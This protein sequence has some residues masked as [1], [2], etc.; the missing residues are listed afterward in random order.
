MEFKIVQDIVANI[1]STV[2]NTAI[3]S[4]RSL[5][6][7]TFSTKVTNFPKT[8]EVKG[9]VVVGNQK[10]VEKQL[11]KIEKP[12]NPIL[13]AIRSIRFPKS[14]E[15]SNFPKPE[16]YPEP[17][18]SVEVSKLPPI[19]FPTT[20]EV[21]NQ[22]T[23]ELRDIRGQVEKVEKAVKGLKLN[24]SINVQAP[25][26]ERVLVPPA[27]VTVQEKEID[28]DKLAQAVASQIPS[29]DYRKLAD[30]IGKKLAEGLVSV[31]GGGGSGRR[32]AYDANGR[33]L[34]T[35]ST[36]AVLKVKNYADA[37]YK[38]ICLAEPGTALSTS[39]WKIVRETIATEDVDFASVGAFTNPATNLSVVQ[40][41][42]YS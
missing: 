33:M 15:I 7:H 32:G 37:T 30:A 16:K 31:G 41:L 11:Q 29:F 4:V 3:A 34:V 42:T 21:S 6:A 1:I 35:T 24:P 9:T 26:P 5:K 19:Q 22:P 27:Q 12:L 13:E 36:E 40:G 2:E 10:N 28:Y 14:F 18:K 25:K 20:T 39:K 8:Q 23:Q 38:Y 17:P